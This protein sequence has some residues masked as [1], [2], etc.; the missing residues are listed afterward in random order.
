MAH[1][2][3]ACPQPNINLPKDWNKDPEQWKYQHCYIVNGNFSA[4]Q[5][6][7]K[8]PETDIPLTTSEA[9]M[10]DS[11]HYEKHLNSAEK[12]VEKSACNE[13]RADNDA[14]K[15]CKHL[16]V[17][18]IT[19][20][21]C[22]RHSCF[23]PDTI[24]DFQKGEQQM[25]IDYALHQTLGKLGSIKKALILYDIACQYSKKFHAHVQASSYLDLSL[26]LKIQWGIGLFHVHGHQDE[27]NSHYSSNFIVGTGQVDGNI[28]KTLW[29]FLNRI[30]GSTHT[31]SFAHFQETLDD[32]MNDSN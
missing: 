18:G 16:A 25:N 24:V 28:L 29:S 22:T 4:E 13:H 20:I 23:V 2:C 11:I 7:M 27:C 26:G 31:M 3:A 6:K 14:N 15:I 5:I 21:A 9:F 12:T 10:T 8:W 32:H 1:Y 30:S 19:A 17:T